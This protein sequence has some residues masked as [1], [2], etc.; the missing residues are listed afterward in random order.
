M[1]SSGE[2]FPIIHPQTQHNAP[3]DSKLLKSVW[4]L[5]VHTLPI[6]IALAL[7]TLGAI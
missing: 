7:R 5:L 6:T 2:Q 4:F 1:L 3:E